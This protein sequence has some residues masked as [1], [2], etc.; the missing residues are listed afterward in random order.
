MRDERAYLLDDATSDLKLIIKADLRDQ[1]SKSDI[2][3]V[4]NG[5]STGRHGVS[6]GVGRRR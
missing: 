1:R 3:K 6:R 4:E 5:T 2:K